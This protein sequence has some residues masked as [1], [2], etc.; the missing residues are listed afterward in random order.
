LESLTRN[1]FLK[2]VGATA[3]LALLPKGSW[4]TTVFRRLRPADAAWS[5]P[6]AWKQLNRVVGGNLF[7]VTSPLSVKQLPD[8]LQNPYYRVISPA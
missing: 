6:L 4:S 5:S 8:N 1:Q 3:A 7:R 2:T